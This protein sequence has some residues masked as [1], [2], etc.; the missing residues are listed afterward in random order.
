MLMILITN[1][2]YIGQPDV[3]TEVIIQDKWIYSNVIE[4]ILYKYICDDKKLINSN[5]VINI[6]TYIPF[7]R[8]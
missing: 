8:Y 7:T 1:I 5:V 3:I 6:N 4:Y 2:S